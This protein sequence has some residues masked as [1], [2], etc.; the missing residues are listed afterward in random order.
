MKTF[1]LAP[2]FVLSLVML[3]SG[4]LHAAPDV[5][6]L[7]RHAEKAI[8]EESDPELSEQGKVRAEA[9]ADAL[10]SAGI[11]RIF[12]TQFRRTQLTAAP[13][14]ERLGLQIDIVE[15][16]APVSDHV[17][18]LAAAVRSQSAG[19]LVVGHSNTIPALLRE[20]GGPSLANLC[21]SSF[22]H[23]F[24]LR[25]EPKPARILHL[26][27]GRDDPPPDDGCL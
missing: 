10:A 26:R 6:V 5:V 16:G 3:G 24:V 4:P 17:A 23:A 15:A 2:L 9:L 1:R 7:V 13:L 27:Y 25:L 11:T 19:V 14:A 18:A 8:G 20:L 21:E 12:A 22:G